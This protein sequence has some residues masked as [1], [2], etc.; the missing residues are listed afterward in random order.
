MTPAL[1]SAAVLDTVT[2]HPEGISLQQVVEDLA[3]RGITARP[4]HVGI[5]LNRYLRTDRLELHDGRWRAVDR[6]T[7]TA[8]TTS[9]YVAS[10]HVL[11]LRR[12]P[13]RRRVR[14]GIRR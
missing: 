3:R 12:T 9:P 13:V 10:T 5:Y 2:A 8:P 14:R 1:L 11:E 4:S 7:A 6:S